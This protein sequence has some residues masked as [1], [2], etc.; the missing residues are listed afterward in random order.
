MLAKLLFTSTAVY[1]ALFL[2]V[3]L[4]LMWLR[5]LQQEHE[6]RMADYSTDELLPEDTYPGREWY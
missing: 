2:F 6:E 1:I 5:L 4:S 3:L